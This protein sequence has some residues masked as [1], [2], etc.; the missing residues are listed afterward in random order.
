MPHAHDEKVAPL[1]EARA[2]DV[3]VSHKASLDVATAAERTV[4]P[5]LFSAL[6]GAVLRFA[7]GLHVETRPDFGGRR[8]LLQRNRGIVPCRR[9]PADVPVATLE[10]TRGRALRTRHD[11]Q[12]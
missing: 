3:A 6:D 11:V 7:A 9:F 4:V 5:E 2:A 8:D 1:F 10:T 12:R